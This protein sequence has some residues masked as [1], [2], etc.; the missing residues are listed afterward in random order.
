MKKIGVGVFFTLVFASCGD[1]KNI[2]DVSGIKVDVAIER[3]DKDFFKIDSTNPEQGLRQL[4]A[5]YPNFYNDYM[6]GILGVSGGAADTLTQRM[7]KVILEN[8]A[9]LYAAVAPKLSNTT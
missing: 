2:P 6:Q 1:D 8:Y 4:Q 7:A 9:P 3:F 5:T